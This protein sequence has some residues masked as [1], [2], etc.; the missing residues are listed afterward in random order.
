MNVLV[1]VPDLIIL[2]TFPY[3]HQVLVLACTQYVAIHG[4]SKLLYESRIIRVP[5]IFDRF[6]DKGTIY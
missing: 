2:T 1:N 4:E 3:H 6:F 5:E